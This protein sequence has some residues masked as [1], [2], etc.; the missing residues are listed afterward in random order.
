MKKRSKVLLLGTAVLGS[1]GLGV[2][3]YKYRKTINSIKKETGT[4]GSKVGNQLPLGLLDYIKYNIVGKVFDG[5][6]AKP[7]PSGVNVPEDLK[8]SG[9]KD[10][11]CFSKDFWGDDEDDEEDD[12]N[13]YEDDDFYDDD[14]FY[15][16]DLDE[17]SEKAT[18]DSQSD[19]GFWESDLFKESDEDKPSDFNGIDMT[20]ADEETV[21]DVLSGNTGTIVI[22][23]DVERS[24]NEE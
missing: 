12:D 20:P 2:S 21:K 18:K 7:K 11:C 5:E 10:G 9:V 22:G 6:F 14:D 8:P 13:Y 4:V 24:T 19:D 17:I 1:V 23:D 16:D 3:Y 15:E